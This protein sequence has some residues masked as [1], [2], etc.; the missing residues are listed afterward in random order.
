VHGLKRVHII[1]YRKMIATY[2][3]AALF[4]NIRNN[5]LRNFI[6]SCNIRFIYFLFYIAFI[7]LLRA[8]SCWSVYVC[9]RPFTNAPLCWRVGCSLCVCTCVPN[10]EAQY[11]FSKQVHNHALL[12]SK[13]PTL[14]RGYGRKMFLYSL[15]ILLRCQ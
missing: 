3:Y 11:V 5:V 6:Q 15:F 2:L 13:P 1:L 14:W 9:I 8:H 10:C 7:I 4:E 12:Q